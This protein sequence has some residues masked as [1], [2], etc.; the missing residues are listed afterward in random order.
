VPYRRFEPLRPY[1][2]Q[3]GDGELVASLTGAQL[4]DLLD[5]LVR[6]RDDDRDYWIDHTV[7]DWLEG[8]GADGE[9]VARMRVHVDRRGPG[10]LSWAPESA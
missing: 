5:L 3:A 10:E 7:L 1:R 2:L 4:D 8:Q 6:E 9:L